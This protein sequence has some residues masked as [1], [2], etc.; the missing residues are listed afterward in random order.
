MSGLRLAVGSAVVFAAMAVLF[1]AP[2]DYFVQATFVATGCMIIVAFALEGIGLPH[3]LKI[4]PIAIGLGSAL[5]L[6]L[7][8]LGGAW[9]VATFHPLG[10]TSAL[11]TSIYSLI[12]SPSNPQYLQV[13]V[14][15]FDAAGY[16]SF[17]RGILQRKLTP[18]IGVG[19]AVVVAVVDALLH[20]ISLNPLWVGATFVTDLV[21]GLAYRYGNGRTASFTSHFVWDIAIFILRPVT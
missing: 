16:E 14:L 18:R 12:A 9:M 15:L 4:K 2:H 21:W 5:F 8:F 6:Y 19:S 17:F 7:V 1:T 13:A 10:I 20:V 3:E 11:E